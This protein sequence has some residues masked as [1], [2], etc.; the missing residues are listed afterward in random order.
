MTDLFLEML[1]TCEDGR[2]FLLGGKPDVAKQTINNLS[3]MYRDRI[4]AKLVGA[5]DGYFSEKETD[6]VIKKIR[7][8]NAIYCL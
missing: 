7:K 4:I 2:V 8:S 1:F 3:I 6:L 5:H